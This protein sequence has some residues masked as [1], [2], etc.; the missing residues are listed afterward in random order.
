MA[1]NNSTGDVNMRVENNRNAW[2]MACLLLLCAFGLS[3]RPLCAQDSIPSCPSPSYAQKPL[4]PLLPLTGAADSVAYTP[5]ALPV[6]FRETKPNCLQDSVQSLYALFEKMRQIHAGLRDDTLRILHV[7]D[8]HVRGHVFPQTVDSLL[9]HNFGPMEYVEMGI[10]GATCLT[11][12]HAKRIAAMAQARPDLLIVSLGTNECHNKRYNPHT[13]YHQMDEL[14]SLIGAALPGVPVLL[15]TPPGAYESY[16][17]KGRKRT[18]TVNPRTEQGAQTICDYA[19][20]HGYVVWDLFRIA[21]G[22][23]R[24]CLNWLEAGLMQADHIHFLPQGYALQG[25]MFYLSF[26]QAYNAYVLTF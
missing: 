13:H 5:V 4:R 10:N 22:S 23:R 14:F 21:G 8:S 25:A 20:Q 24:A 2:R 6:S 3:C 9:R 17:R 11:F 12:T 19:A 18:Y 1:N 16:R 7:G 15:T 26:I